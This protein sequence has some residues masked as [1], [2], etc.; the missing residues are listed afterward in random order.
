MPNPIHFLSAVIFAWCSALMGRARLIFQKALAQ[1]DY[2]SEAFLPSATSTKTIKYSDRTR[3][4]YPMTFLTLRQR[5]AR[6]NAIAG[7][8]HR[9]TLPLLVVLTYLLSGAPASVSAFAEVQ[10]SSSATAKTSPPIGILVFHVTTN[11]LSPAKLTVSPGR[12]VLRVR[13]GISVSKP[14]VTLTAPTAAKLVNKQPQGQSQ[15]T[16]DLIDLTPGTYTLSVGT[17]GSRTAVI[18]VTGK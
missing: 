9:S 14:I 12:Y 1:R 7:R 8:V 11:A 5:F 10:S 13:N 6:I 16:Q 3:R 2:L 15:S 18:L 4:I 17:S